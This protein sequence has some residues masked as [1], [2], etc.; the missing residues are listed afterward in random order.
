M[1]YK[2]KKVYVWT[3][4]VRPDKM[5]WYQE[6]EYIQSSWNQYINTGYKASNNTK[7][8]ISMWWWSS[9]Q[10]FQ[11]VFW[12]RE[13][14]SSTWKWF[15]LWYDTQYMYN[16]MFNKAFDIQTTL[17]SFIDGNNYVIQMSQDWI[18]QNWTKKYTISSA[19]FTSP[20]NMTLF[21]L[22]DNGTVKEYWL[23]KMYYTKIWDNWT[24]VRDFVPCYRKSDNVIWLYDLV[25]S[26]FYTN[27][28]SWTFT[29]WPD[30]N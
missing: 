6:V 25:N 29:K 11:C 13:A 21:A 9:V 17:L 15:Q 10:R 23:Y 3:T 8:E 1:W 20:V 16:W 22:N 14:Y 24:L 18:Y 2:V 5:P 7:I 4:K 12:C 28:W 19:T 27:S 30:V 26:V